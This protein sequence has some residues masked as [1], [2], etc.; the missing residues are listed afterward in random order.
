M[1]EILVL[2][3]KDKHNRLEQR[4]RTAM[5]KIQKEAFKLTIS[6]LKWNRLTEN[7]AL[8]MQNIVFISPF[9]LFSIKSNLY[10][11]HSAN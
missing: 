7:N 11:P 10:N 5:S 2:H 3:G 1:I 9:L 4:Y 6:I 8:P